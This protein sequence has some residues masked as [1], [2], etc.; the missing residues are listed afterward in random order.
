MLRVRISINSTDVLDTHVVRIAGGSRPDDINTYLFP[1]GR[2][3]KHRYGDG[4]KKL[5]QK[6]LRKVKKF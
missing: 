6:I 3:V 1:D 4:A 5:A 2:T